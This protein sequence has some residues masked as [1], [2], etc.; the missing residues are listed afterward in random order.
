MQ[1]HKWAEHSI[2]FTGFH[3]IYCL[4]FFF[5]WAKII[6]IAVNRKAIFATFVCPCSLIEMEAEM[7]Y[8]LSC[9]SLKPRLC[10]CQRP[11]NR[12]PGSSGAAAAP[13]GRDRGA[14]AAPGCRSGFGACET[15]HRDRADTE[16]NSCHGPETLSMGRFKSH[17]E[18]LLI[19]APPTYSSTGSFLSIVKQRDN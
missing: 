14:P 10:C 12:S 13:R 18:L 3:D 7:T 8:H 4:P 2:I 9:I 15:P 1:P 11:G 17:V 6:A 19:F 5:H 16:S